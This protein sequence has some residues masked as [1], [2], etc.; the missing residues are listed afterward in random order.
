MTI[1]NTVLGGTDWADGEVLYAAD[2]NDTNDE[3][4]SYAI[5]KSGSGSDSTERT[6]TGDTDWTLASAT[7]NLVFGGL[8]TFLL[9]V[10]FKCK[11]KSSSGSY[12][13]QVR[14]TINDGVSDTY[15]ARSEAG[16]NLESLPTALSDFTDGTDLPLIETVDTSYPSTKYGLTLAPCVEINGEGTATVEIR[17]DNSLGTVSIDDVSYNIVYVEKHG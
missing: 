7:S 9:G 11:L 12:K 8:G 6:H 16:N 4:L 14:I 15:I 10:R 2:L 13:A 1:K 5:I 17:I 3:I